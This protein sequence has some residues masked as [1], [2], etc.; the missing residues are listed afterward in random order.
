MGLGRSGTEKDDPPGCLRSLGVW[1]QKLQEGE[2]AK[3][4]KS[5]GLRPH[6]CHC[7]GRTCRVV[8]GRFRDMGASGLLRLGCL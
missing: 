2:L 5:A 6:C 8:E 7:I 1:K 3:A 4:Q